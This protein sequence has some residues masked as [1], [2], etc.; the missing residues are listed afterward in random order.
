MFEINND[1]RRILKLPLYCGD[2]Q[3]NTE[4][5]I[6]FDPDKSTWQVIELKDNENRCKLVVN[7]VTYDVGT[8][9]QDVVAAYLEQGKYERKI[10]T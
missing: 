1:R 5:S 8:S 10:P 6:S 4:I 2:A 3:F 7:G 9:A